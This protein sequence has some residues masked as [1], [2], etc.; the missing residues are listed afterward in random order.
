MSKKTFQPYNDR[1]LIELLRKTG[2]SK[3]RSDFL[4][5]HEQEAKSSL[6]RF[7]NIIREPFPVL[8]HLFAGPISPIAEEF[9]CALPDGRHLL[10]DPHLPAKFSA[11]LIIVGASP[12]FTIYNPLVAFEMDG[13]LFNLVPVTAI[14]NETVV[15]E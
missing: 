8:K 10:F 1:K 15:Y 6:V 3:I 11:M 12:H 2:L 4:P 5:D 14:L 13:R 7:S 9:F